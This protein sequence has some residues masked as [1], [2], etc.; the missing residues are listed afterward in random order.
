MYCFLI[1]HYPIGLEG[2]ESG[3]TFQD[4]FSHYCDNIIVTKMNKQLTNDYLFQ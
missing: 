1:Y 3:V 4:D 2:N